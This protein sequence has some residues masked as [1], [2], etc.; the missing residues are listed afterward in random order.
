MRNTARFGSVMAPEERLGKAISGLPGKARAALA[1]VAD[2]EDLPLVAG[3]WNDGDGGCLV[4]NTVRTLS[5]GADEGSQ[6]LDLRMLELL[7][8]LSSR[9]LNELIVAWDE[10]AEQEGKDSDAA[11][12]RLLRGALARADASAVPPPPEPAA[13]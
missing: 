4:A 5:L 2:R 1:D 10:A 11:L 12:R 9:D 3:S 8:T 13:L 7:P 6:T